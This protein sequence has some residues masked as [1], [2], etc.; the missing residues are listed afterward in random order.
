VK[1]M[2]NASRIAQIFRGLAKRIAD[3]QDNP[4]PARTEGRQPFLPTMRNGVVRPQEIVEACYE[5]LEEV[6]E[7]AGSDGLWNRFTVDDVIWEFVD[8][9]IELPAD[10]R[11][12]DIRSAVTWVTGRFTETPTSWVVDRLVYG[13]HESCAGLTFG[14]FRFLGEDIGKM[15][16]GRATFPGFPSGSQVLARMEVAAI[17]D[18]SAIERAENILD[19]HL[20]VLNALCSHEA[21]SWIQVSRVD[22]ISRA[23]SAVRCGQSEDS[24]GSMLVSGRNFK[25]PLMR[26]DLEAILSRD[27]GARVSQMLAGAET[28]FSGRVLSGYQ[29]AGAACVD[30]HPERS[31]LMFAIAIESAVLGKDTKSEL[32]H[33]LATR[34][35]H[36]IG[37]HLDGRKLVAKTVSQLYDRRSKIVHTGQYGVPRSEA[38]LIHLYCMSALG[39][40]VVSPAF[41]QFTENAEL[42]AWFAERMLDGPNHFIPKPPEPGV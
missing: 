15:L 36:L 6:A 34:V 27:L 23:H 29:F 1:R 24:M 19:E 38:A 41:A 35:A 3:F 16:D 20:M 5:V 14:K 4:P 13:L 32:T 33:Q 31:F 28:P 30:T 40:L 11:E 21:P 39:M 12:P 8:R 2:I 25:I 18:E 7:I 10:R 42:E 37:R 17:N 26:A 22:Y 9:I